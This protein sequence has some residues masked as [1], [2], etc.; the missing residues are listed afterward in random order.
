ML[1]PLFHSMRPLQ[2]KPVRCIELLSQKVP[3]SAWQIRLSQAFVFTE[4]L[5]SSP[6]IKSTSHEFQGLKSLDLTKK[7]RTRH[8][9]VFCNF[10]F[11]FLKPDFVASDVCKT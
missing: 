7:M 9:F 10:H 8:K 3:L 6:E 4:T 1:L 2:V 5:C 11:F